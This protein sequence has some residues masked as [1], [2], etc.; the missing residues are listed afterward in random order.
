MNGTSLTNKQK[1]F[2]NVCYLIDVSPKNFKGGGQTHLTNL[3]RELKRFELAARSDFIIFAGP[4]SFTLIRFLWSFL[5]IPQVIFYHVFRKKFSL[6]HA[7]SVPAMISGKILSSILKIPIV[8]T[9]HGTWMKSRIEKFVLTGIRYDAQITVSRNF[10]QFPNINKNVAYIPNGVDLSRFRKL[11]S[12]SLRN[13]TVLFV[14][15][16]SDPAKGF[17]ILEDAMKLV[18]Q[19]IPDAK[20]LVA[21]GSV[22]RDGVIKMYSKADLFVLPSL[23]EGFPLTLLEAWAARLPVV[24]TAVGDLPYLFGMNIRS[25]RNFQRVES[26]IRLEVYETSRG[27]VVKPGDPNALVKA[28]L[29]A[30]EN[31]DLAK[32]GENGY[33]LAKRYT[34]KNVAQKTLRVYR[35]IC[36]TF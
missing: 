28:I 14:G 7:H 10:L 23:S 34:W 15:R 19:E 26:G 22:P 35:K 1:R 4:S 24:A 31:P 11:P 5:V 29:M 6:I 3:I 2:T 36:S 13:F 18:K 16:K 25:L 12:R 30:F 21:D 8:M 32:L 33:N 17:K 9:V 20:L 27:Y